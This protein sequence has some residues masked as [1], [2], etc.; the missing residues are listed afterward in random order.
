MSE[1]GRKLSE[2]AKPLMKYFKSSEINISYANPKQGLDI[3][4]KHFKDSI[5]VN[6][7][8]GLTMKFK[9]WWFN[10]RASNTEPLMRLNAE[11]NSQKMLDA[12]VAEIKKL[13]K[14]IL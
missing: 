8:D 2:L 14:W 7:I 4:K 3:V 1:S 5:E 10:L 11:A 9:D 12:K 6:S 13:F